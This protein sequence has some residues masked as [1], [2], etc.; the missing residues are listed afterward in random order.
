MKV[1]IDNEE[2]NKKL[3]IVSIKSVYT[4]SKLE[5]IVL[6]LINEDRAELFNIIIVDFNDDILLST[7]YYY[8]NISFRQLYENEDKEQLYMSLEQLYNKYSD[9]SKEREEQQ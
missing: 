9:Y 5:N 2:R 4:G 7:Y 8:K 6:E 1:L 3:D